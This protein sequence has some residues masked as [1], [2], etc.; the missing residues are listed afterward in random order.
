MPKSSFRLKMVYGRNGMYSKLKH[1]DLTINLYMDDDAET[2]CNKHLENGGEII[3]ATYR[4]HMLRIN[5]TTLSDIILLSTFFES[6][7]LSDEWITE[8]FAMSNK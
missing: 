8:M 7:C 2:R 3:P 5:N 6:K 1:I 4:S